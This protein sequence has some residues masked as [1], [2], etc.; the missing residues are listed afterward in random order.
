MANKQISNLFQAQNPAIASYDWTDIADSTGKVL[1]YF[2]KTED[3]SAESLILSDQAI[4]SNFNFRAGTGEIR[5]DS[6]E[7]SAEA[8]S[9][10]SG[11]TT[12]HSFT[13]GPFNTPKTLKGTAYT[14][15]KV[16]FDSSSDTLAKIVL[17]ITLKKGDDTI[18]TKDSPDF[19]NSSIG[20]KLF[21]ACWNTDLTIPRTHFKK[22][23]SL[24][25]EIKGVATSSS[26]NQ[27]Y[28]LC[29]SPLQREMYIVL[30]SQGTS[31]ETDS[32]IYIPFD[33]EL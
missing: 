17:T 32:F 4:N 13:L 7:T 2:L 28:Y 6:A 33:I 30:T 16:L 26:G 31:T 8:V 9:F 3:S 21:N 15:L 22:G 25:I 27:R 10:P 19:T 14:N 5:L 23:E 29:L 24:T 20:D 11:N 18:V 1:F 12:T